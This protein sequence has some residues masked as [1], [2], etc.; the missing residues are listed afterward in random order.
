MGFETF[1]GDEQ[2]DGEEQQ[3]WSI[4]WSQRWSQRF[5]EEEVD[6]D[7]ADGDIDEEREIDPDE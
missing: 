7:G 1:Y 2:E 4:R 6:A 5:F 3:R